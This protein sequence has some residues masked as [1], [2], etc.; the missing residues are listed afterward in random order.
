MPN[1]EMKNSTKFLKT[2]ES[3]PQKSLAADFVSES[4]QAIVLH[5]ALDFQFSW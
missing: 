3:L 2:V 1:V 5:V 4:R